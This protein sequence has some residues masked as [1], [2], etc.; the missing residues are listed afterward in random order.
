MRLALLSGTGLSSPICTTLLYSLYMMWPYSGTMMYG[1]F[2]V[3]SFLALFIIPLLAWT[4]VWK[5]LALWRAAQRGEQYWFIALLVI[6]TFGLLE[7]LYLFVFS[8][9]DADKKKHS[10]S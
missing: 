10:A 6:N 2:G 1:P 4:L 5:G 7:I 9:D 3:P 8:K